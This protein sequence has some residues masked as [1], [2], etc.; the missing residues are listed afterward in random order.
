VKDADNVVNESERLFEAY[1]ISVHAQMNV[2]IIV[3]DKV[4]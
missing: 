3:I 4:G 1:V 2:S